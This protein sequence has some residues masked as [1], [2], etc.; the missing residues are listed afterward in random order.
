MVKLPSGEQYEYGPIKLDKILS[1]RVLS[2]KTLM[3]KMATTNKLRLGTPA[4]S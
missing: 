4:N 2:L 3:I 1:Q